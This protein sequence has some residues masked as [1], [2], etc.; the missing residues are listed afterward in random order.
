[1]VVYTEESFAERNYTNK[2]A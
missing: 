2:L 1:L